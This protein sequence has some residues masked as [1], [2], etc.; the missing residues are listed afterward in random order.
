[1]GL[2]MKVSGIVALTGLLCIPGWADV[3]QAQPAAQS[4]TLGQPGAV[5]YIEGQAALG[6]QP[7]NM[8]AVGST[9]L[10]AG[11]S[12]TTQDGKAEILLTP[13][14]FLRI[15]PNSS[16][17]MDSPGLANTSLTLLRGRALVEVSEIH[18]EN[19]ITIRLG[20][21][22]VRLTDRGLY[23]F[24]ADHNQIRV[25]DGVAEA[26]VGGNT[27][28]IH[29]GHQLDLNAAKLKARGFD[30]KADQDDFYRW[31]SLR[32]SYLAE[33]NV[34]A[35]RTYYAGGPGW[36]GAG[37][38]W[39]PWFTAYT[40]IPGDGFFYS[41]FGWGFY[42]PWAVYSA[43]VFYGGFGHFNH[44]FGPG[45][46][47]PVTA[48]RSSGVAHGFARSGAAH[49]FTPAAR[50]GGGFSGGAGGFRGGGGFHGGRR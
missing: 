10:Q 16:V 23:D 5:N 49:G 20:G 2:R 50:M 19:D 40:W 7:L 33:A 29:G 25:F 21:A 39:D 31:A 48:F 1:M 15:G 3:R 6:T 28:H 42:S 32:S 36:Y 34:D 35:A 22:D 12:L 37:W 14:V 24:D 45:Y 43:P 11:Q 46:R 38:Y 18:R 8:N 27:M 30:K 44:H 4:A 17:R 13:G 26:A 41:P 47:P 9:Q